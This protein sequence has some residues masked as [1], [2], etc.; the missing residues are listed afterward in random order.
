[1]GGQTAATRQ[2]HTGVVTTYVSGTLV[3]LLGAFASPDREDP[4]WRNQITV[5]FAV[6]AGALLGAVL[7]SQARDSVPVLPIALTLLV[8]GLSALRARARRRSAT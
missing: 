1:M 5:I 4:E 6:V 2:W 8:A 3:G 7:L